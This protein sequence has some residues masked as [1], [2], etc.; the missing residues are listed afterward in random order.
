MSILRIDQEVFWL[1]VSVN[2]SSFVKDFENLK[3]LLKD[4]FKHLLPIVTGE[5]LNVIK[6]MSSGTFF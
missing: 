1:D 3:Q 5:C 6:Q 2:K 4:R